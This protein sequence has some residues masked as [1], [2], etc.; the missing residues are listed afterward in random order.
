MMRRW[1]GVALIAGSLSQ[2]VASAQS[3]APTPYGP[4]RMPEPV[5]LCQAAPPNVVPG[6]L[7]PEQA[8]PGP[9]PE[10]SLPAGHSSA[11]QAETYAVEA[12][13]Y[14]SIGTT[15]WQRNRLGHQPIAVQ[16]QQ[17]ANLAA[18]GLVVPTIGRDTGAN[19]PA[20]SPVILDSSNVSEA[21]EWGPKLTIGY[22]WNEEC[23]F[24]V[25]GFGIFS[26]SHSA[27][28]IMP[29]L[30]DGLFS[31]NPFGFT[32]DNGLWRQA[33]AIQVTNTSQLF[34]G[35]ANF[36]FTNPGIRDW[37]L[38]IGV[39]FFDLDETVDILTNDDGFV[40]GLDPRRL[41]TYS[42]RTQNRLAALNFGTEYGFTIVPGVNFGG[43]AKWAPGANF[44]Q[45]QVSL[46][47]G[48][49]FQGFN[50]SHS[51]TQFGQ[52]FEAGFWFDIAFT[53]KAKMR[54]GYNAMWLLGASV[55]QDAIDFN[56]NNPYGNTNQ[57]GSLF[58][59]G[60]S[61]ELQFLF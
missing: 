35:E 44:T 60:P 38:I 39:R 40:Q 24:E 48:D 15:A 4:A 5:P 36:R 53:E 45:T 29:G 17:Y 50:N 54:A 49:G 37:E 1:I 27:S 52:I 33:D 14:S 20:K 26:N 21:Y 11:F 2:G 6:P 32:G 13:F 23:A 56:L 9:G 22:I 42:A 7:T 61:V 41:A 18:A 25:S 8:P 55:A 30:V 59:H 43:T 51:N 34:N 10:L 57:H 19:P 16:D 47:R 58:W 3:Y 31:G 28:V 12:A 46:T